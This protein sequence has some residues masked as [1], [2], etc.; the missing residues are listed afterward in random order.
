MGSHTITVEL[1]L[2][3][4]CWK[5]FPSSLLAFNL[6]S[7]HNSTS[8]R[9]LLALSRTHSTCTVKKGLPF[10]RPQPGCHL[11]NS[12]WTGIIYL[13]PSRESFVSDIPAGDGKIVHLFFTVYR[14]LDKNL[15]PVWLVCR[16]GHRQLEKVIHRQPKNQQPG[17]K[18]NPQHRH[19][20]TIRQHLTTKS[21][22]P[23]TRNRLQP[24]IPTPDNHQT[25]LDN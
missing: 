1:S 14:P 9:I 10:S 20:T 5:S 19:P 21:R 13:F 12:P 8:T 7:E 25:A 3:Q 22:Q 15:P 11:P 17:M 2:S 4:L 23:V 18:H 16:A 6:N 24:P